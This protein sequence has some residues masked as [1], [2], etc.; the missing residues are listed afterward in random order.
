MALMTANKE[1]HW[2]LVQPYGVHP[3]GKSIALIGTPPEWLAKFGK[4]S[5][6]PFPA[7]PDMVFSVNTIQEAIDARMVAATAAAAIA[8]DVMLT[9]EQLQRKIPALKNAEHYNL[10]RTQ[11]GFPSPRKQTAGWGLRELADV[12]SEAA[13]DQWLADMKTKATQI[14]LF[15]SR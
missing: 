3:S 15:L 8:P 13:V 9:S 12:W 1:K 4:P 11:Y 14:A 5:D 10:A 2:V 6:E 7:D